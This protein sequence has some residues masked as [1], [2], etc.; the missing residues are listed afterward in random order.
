M[1]LTYKGGIAPLQEIVIDLANRRAQCAGVNCREAIE[2]EWF[3]L[4]VGA[5][6]L[7]ITSVPTGVSAKVAVRYRERHG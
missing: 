7:R 1:G 2:G 3:D 5:S 6:V 4:P